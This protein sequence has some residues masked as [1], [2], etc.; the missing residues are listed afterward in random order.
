MAPSLYAWKV[1]A[2]PKS[3]TRNSP[4]ARAT[5]SSRRRG[6]AMH[7]GPGANRCCSQSPTGRPRRRSASGERLIKG[8]R[9]APIA[10]SEIRQ[11]DLSSFLV[12]VMHLHGFPHSVDPVGVAI[13]KRVDGGTILGFQ[14]EQAAHRRFAVGGHQGSGRRHGD[15]MTVGLVEM[16]AM[17][18]V[19]FCAGLK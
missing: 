16:D 1:R 11:G 7:T 14:N 18:A 17:S 12:V 13:G 19:V 2:P 8:A 15:A 10:S 3:V 5:S 6:S 4:G 9:V